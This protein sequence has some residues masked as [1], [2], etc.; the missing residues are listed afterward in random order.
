MGK[1]HLRVLRLAG[2]QMVHALLIAR[3]GL[4]RL[5]QVAVAVPLGATHCPQFAAQG[6]GV[7]LL[8]H[9]LQQLCLALLQPACRATVLSD[10]MI[11]RCVMC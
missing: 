1:P 5:F 11:N 8:L 10:S 7:P 3:L 2:P 6:S 4:L 9:L